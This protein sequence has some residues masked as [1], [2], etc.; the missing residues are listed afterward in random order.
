MTVGYT[1]FPNGVESATGFIG[2][3]TGALAATTITASGAVALNGG[4]TCDTDKVV[5]AD[6]TGNTTL[7]AT[8]TVGVDA[9]GHD[10]KF[11]GDTT[12]KYWLW[13]ESADKVINTGAEDIT[14][15]LTVTGNIAANGG[16]TGALT[17]TVAGLVTGTCNTVAATGSNQGDAAAIPN[18]TFN[19]VTAAD[20]TK[21][22]KLP[23]AAA[24]LIRTIKN[25][26]NAVL[27]VYPN[28]DD[29]INAIAANTEISM[30]AF[31]CATFFCY[32]GTTWY[33]SP[34]LPS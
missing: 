10:V 4:V 15:V 33:T 32:D 5:I 17:G 23:A 9:T 19:L 24:G 21:G 27:K 2:P 30:A 16:I 29:A 3:V 31:T 12:G 26:A 1:N 7:K 34:L 28:T 14:G 8:L 6:T 25:N 20:A 11:F 22:V 18:A 13:D